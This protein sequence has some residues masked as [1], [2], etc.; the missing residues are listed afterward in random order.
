[1]EIQRASIIHE[2]EKPPPP[3]RPYPGVH[4]EADVSEQRDFKIHSVGFF[5]EPSYIGFPSVSRSRLSLSDLVSVASSGRRALPK[6]TTTSASGAEC[7][8]IV[9]VATDNAYRSYRACILFEPH[10]PLEQPA[11]CEFCIAPATARLEFP[12]HSVETLCV[13][14]STN[15]ATGPS[16]GAPVGNQTAAIGREVVFSC[17][18]RNIGKYKVMTARTAGRKHEWAVPIKF[19]RI[20]RVDSTLSCNGVSTARRVVARGIPGESTLRSFDSFAIPSAAAS[21][22]FPRRTNAPCRKEFY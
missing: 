8:S 20:R 5:A 11:T 17:S 22:K 16:F 6:R 10:P 18:V 4:H 19:A 13:S 9:V 12:T 21:G 15:T 3:S 7:C 14:D 1:M 2:A